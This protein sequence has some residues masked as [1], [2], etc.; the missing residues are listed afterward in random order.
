VGLRTEAEG[1]GKGFWCRAINHLY[2][3]HAMQVQ[4]SEHVIGKH[5]PHLEKLLRLTADE[6]LFAQSP[7]HRNALYNLITEQDITIEPK[8]VNAYKADNYLNIDII[9]NAEH[10]LP[11]S[12]FARRFFVPK[13]SDEHANDHK[14]FEAISRQLHDGGYEALL[15]HLLYEVDVRDFNVRAVP[16]TAQLAEQVAF[17]RKG[18]DLLVETACHMAVVPCQNK[19]NPGFSTTSGYESRSGFDYF[20]DHHADRDLQ[21]LGA[22]R[23]KR[24]LANHWG[25]VTGPAARTQQQGS[26]LTGISWPSLA[27]LRA[28]FEAK[29]G[30]QQWM[31]KA[32]QWSAEVEQATM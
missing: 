14:Y 12:G 27:E 22:L 8:F 11:V 6:A 20:I 3:I 19:L 9:S 25:C 21:R 4:N 23:A 2:G 31:T 30:P 10:F 5:N 32:E 17:S 28:K 16:K 1:T 18:I 7:L 29:Y 15:Y 24:A 13:V 26:R